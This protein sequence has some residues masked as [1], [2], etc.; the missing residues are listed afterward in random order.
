MDALKALA[1]AAKTASLIDVA[2]V[3]AELR[4]RGSIFNVLERFSRLS[5]VRLGQ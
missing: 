4:V 3:R 5:A 1:P 2:S